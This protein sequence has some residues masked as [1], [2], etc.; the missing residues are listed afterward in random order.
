[1][2]AAKGVL[3]LAVQCLNQAA[4]AEHDDH[5]WA[6]HMGGKGLGVSA[7]EVSS[8]QP[9]R[10]YT[11]RPFSLTLAYS[12]VPVMVTTYGAFSPASGTFLAQQNEI[13][14]AGLDVDALMNDFLLAIDR[15]LAPDVTTYLA[16]ADATDYQT[17]LGYKWALADRILAQRLISI[18]QSIDDKA[19]PPPAKTTIEAF[20]QSLLV[21]L[22]NAYAVAAVV[23]FDMSV[24]SP[25]TSPPGGTPQ[26]FGPFKLP[27]QD[28]DMP[29]PYALSSGRLPIVNGMQKVAML[30]TVP[31]AEAAAFFQT[32][33]SY[34][35]GFIQFDFE[36]NE[37]DFGYTP[38]S[39]LRFILPQGAPSVDLGT[40]G[41]PVPLRRYPS[42][43]VIQSQTTGGGVVTPSGNTI[44]EEIESV[45]VWP[46]TLNVNKVDPAP[47]DEMTLVLTLN[48]GLIPDGDNNAR[49]DAD[50]TGL[51]PLMLALLRFRAAYQSLLPALLTAA[52]NTPAEN[53]ALLQILVPLV[54]NVVNP[55]NKRMAEAF[56]GLLPVKR[57]YTFKFDEYFGE[58]NKARRVLTVLTDHPAATPAAALRTM[59]TIQ[60]GE[61]HRAVPAPTNR[62]PN[63]P[64]YTWQVS[65]D[66]GAVPSPGTAFTIVWP[67]FRLLH[68]QTAITTAEVT[69]NADIGVDVNSEL[70]Y[71]TPV[72]SP[73][74]AVVPMVA[75][76]TKLSQSQP[77]TTVDA[78]LSAVFNALLDMIL[79]LSVTVRVD[80]CF[81]L[82]TPATPAN[83]RPLM[84]RVAAV[85]ATGVPIDGKAEIARFVTALAGDIVS[86]AK[87][88][89][90]WPTTNAALA[91]HVVMF[92]SI[93]TGDVPTELPLLKLSEI[94]L[95]LAS[96]WLPT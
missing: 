56:G 34:D 73:R 76:T 96:N 23:E 39:W 81:P 50:D 7:T 84:S 67:E 43:P 63:G 6:V 22:G 36:S 91:L 27:D 92:A 65:Y 86:W 49:Q 55:T 19:V 25:G 90:P 70:I 21:A 41:I 87:N 85:L 77:F 20:K 64:K 32:K 17:L 66:F 61:A 53:L 78:A 10:C 71:K 4:P 88:T 40:V 74:Q 28:K 79:P 72:V 15:I 59:P 93:P 54:D 18:L 44:Q 47:Q 52:T 45:L 80:Y 69:R 1:V 31:N 3:K 82:S 12:Q 13:Q 9:A 46:Y 16:L 35:I 11:M 83:A 58:A 51:T 89:G 8:A 62:D 95:P 75:V 37:T 24:S 2:D 29:P 26:F 42:L 68:Y 33:L 14:V 48:G 94:D 30:A 57:T 38:S 5:L 60:A